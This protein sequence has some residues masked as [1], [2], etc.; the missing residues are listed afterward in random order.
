[1]GSRRR[2][3]AIASPSWVCAFSRTRSASTSVS[4]GVAI[5]DR[6][7]G[8]TFVLSFMARPSVDCLVYPGTSDSRSQ[9]ACSRRLFTELSVIG[10]YCEQ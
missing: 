8:L 6:R 4:V 7:Q 9:H 3:A 5:D 2:A 1:M 10:R